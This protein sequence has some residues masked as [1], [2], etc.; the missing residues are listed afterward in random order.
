MQKP[1]IIYSMPRTRSTAVLQSCV[2]RDKV[3]EPFNNLSLFDVRFNSEGRENQD[4]TNDY[5][6]AYRK[7]ADTYA[8]YA[9]SLTE[10]KIQALFSRLNNPDTVSKII[11]NGLFYFLPARTWLESVSVNQTHDIFVL[12]R[13]LRE[14]ML[15]FIL[16]HKFGFFKETECEPFDVEIQ[17]SDIRMLHTTI[18]NFLRFIPPSGRLISFDKLPSTH[19]DYKNIVLEEQQSLSKLSYISNIDYCEFHIEQIIKYYKDEWDRKLSTL[20]T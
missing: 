19:F 14:Q 1:V 5:I 20:T 4:V 15:S 8:S 2:R 7:I 13:D 6:D 9:N 16:S 3:F 11:C 12:V 10:A 17:S 18:D